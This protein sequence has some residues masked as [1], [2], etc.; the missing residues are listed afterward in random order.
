MGDDAQRGGEHLGELD[1][2]EADQCHRPAVPVDGAQGAD[3]DPV[4]RGE[5]RGGRVGAVEQV[6]DGGLGGRGVVVADPDELWCD[7]DPCAARASV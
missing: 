1:V 6:G 4:V 5:D 3:G 7:G 2:V